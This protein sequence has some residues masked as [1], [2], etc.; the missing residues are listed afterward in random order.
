MRR[1]LLA[2][3]CAS[4]LASCGA[5]SSAV[6]ATNTTLQKP[7]SAAVLFTVIVPRGTVSTQGKKTPKYVSPATQSIA[8]SATAGGSTT[9]NT[10]NCASSQ[11][12]VTLEAPVG[13]DAFVISLYDG[14][15]GTGN[16]LSTGS[17]SQY[18]LA[19]TSNTI[20]ITF[21]GVAVKIAIQASPSWLR[22]GSIGSS[23]IAVSALDADG[24]IIVAPGAYS[25]PIALS[26]SSASS[27]ATISPA[28][29][30]QPGQGAVLT[31]LGVNAPGTT[32]T[33]S[34]PGLASAQVTV[35][36]TTSSPTPSPTPGGT[37]TPTPGGTP[38][39]TPTPTPGGTP[40]PTSAPT[41]TPTPVPTATPTATPAPTPTPASPIGITPYRLNFYGAGNAYSQT[42]NVSESGYSGT[43]TE[44]DTCNGTIA[45]LSP[46]SAGGPSAA[47]TVTPQGAGNCTLT[48]KDSNGNSA[49]VSVT[50][51]ISQ[52]VIN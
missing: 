22:V 37:P 7:A 17:T 45:T 2:L 19:G 43:F 8:I 44:S 36:F 15:N 20:N 41:A 11:C 40:T 29:I 48:I 52:G 10:S 28:S 16:L 38:T 26:L 21:T 13:F 50:V 5:N 47:F 23:N 32:I 12:S 31:Y 46:T 42:F 49:A 33:A 1:A 27:V 51:T 39:P 24:N 18:V 4:A 30:T 35:A 9:S 25:S 14:T 6:P 34:T 3:C